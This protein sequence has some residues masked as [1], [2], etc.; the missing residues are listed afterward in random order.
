MASKLE[1]HVVASAVILGVCLSLVSGV[2]ENRLNNT[3]IP[4]TKYYGFPLRWRTSDPTIGQDFDYP[5]LLAD[6]LFW[7]AIVLA[8]ELAVM[9]LMK[10]NGRSPR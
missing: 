2:I 1:W 6:S 9:G 10:R 7:A 8:I 4:E 5:K 3:Y